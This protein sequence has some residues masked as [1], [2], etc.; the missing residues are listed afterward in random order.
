[1]ITDKELIEIYNIGWKDESNGDW[2]MF[3]YTKPLEKNAYK[4]GKI[5]YIGGDDSESVDSQ[6][7]EEILKY[8]KDF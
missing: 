3:K 7:E 6:S 2:D 1:M 4:H 8:I 5:D